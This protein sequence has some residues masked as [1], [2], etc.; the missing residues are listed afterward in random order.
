MLSYGF[1]DSGLSC[2]NCG[3][4]NV[5]SAEAIDSEGFVDCQNCGS[6]FRA[7]ESAERVETSIAPEPIGTKSWH[8]TEAP[9][10][11]SCNTG[12]WCVIV[13]IFLFVP[14]IIAIPAIICIIAYKRDELFGGS[15]SSGPKRPKSPDTW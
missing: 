5:Y 13:L 7:H 3:A 2:P 6:R 15:K 9:E 10:K 1:N 14:Y 12:L 11:K 8:Y 4:T